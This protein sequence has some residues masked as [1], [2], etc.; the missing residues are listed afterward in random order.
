MVVVLP[1]AMHVID[2]TH[3]SVGRRSKFE[4]QTARARVVNARRVT[5]CT[6]PKLGNKT[7]ELSNESDPSLQCT[8]NLQLNESNA[9]VALSNS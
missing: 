1:H 4:R 5:A 6:R 2:Y 9:L 3:A 8:V 7:S